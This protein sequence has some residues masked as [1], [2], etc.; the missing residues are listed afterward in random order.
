MNIRVLNND[1]TSYGIMAGFESLEFTRAFNTKGAFRLKINAN[2]KTA[3]YIKIDKILYIDDTQIGY[4]DKIVYDRKTGSAGEYV[5]AEGVEIK[6]RLNRIIYPDANLDSDVYTNEYLEVIIKS[7]INKNAGSLASVNRQ[8]PNVATAANQNRGLQID[9]SARYKDLSTE[10]YSLLKSQEMGLTAGI[11]FDNNEIVFD[12]KVGSDLKAQQGMAGGIV[13]SLDTKTA[14]EMIDTDD[15]LSY[16]NLSVTAGLG[17]GADRTIEEVYSGTEPTGYARCEVFTD[18]RDIE[19]DDEITT[20]GARKLSEIS[21]TRAISVKANNLGSYQIGDDYDLGDYISVDAKGELIDAQIIKIKQSYE[22]SAIPSVDIVLNFDTD[23][24]LLSDISAKHMDYD[25]L[26]ASTIKGGIA[27]QYEFLSVG[28]SH[29]FTGLDINADGG[30]YDIL[31]IGYASGNVGLRL[32]YNGIAN[33]STYITRSIRGYDTSIASSEAAES[34]IGSLYN[35]ANSVKATLVLT[36]SRAITT[37]TCGLNSESS[38][39]YRLYLYNQTYRS[40]ISN[41]TSLK[42]LVTS[43]SFAAGTKIIIYK[44]K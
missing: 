11:D 24:T 18:A 32:E 21:K 27:A 26:I 41:I 22:S 44:R 36:N 40:S 37:S 3:K 13:L 17:E 19:S 43:G 30:V 10:I 28:T 6:D 16:K 33:N 7:L 14:L 34:N 12:V 35:K 38:S 39:L 42:F 9:Y 31:V 2:N 5:I 4:I 25:A 23:D 8:I 29:T 1:L 20:R 15:K